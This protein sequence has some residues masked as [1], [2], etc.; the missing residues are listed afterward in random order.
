MERKKP[1]NAAAAKLSRLAHE[2]MTPAQ[3]KARSQ[4]ANEAKR[5]KA[6]GQEPPEPQAWYGL[7]SLEDEAQMI[8]WSRDKRE[9]HE[10][11]K[12][13]PSLCIVEKLN[14]KPADLEVVPR[15]ASDASAEASAL[16]SLA[17]LQNWRGKRR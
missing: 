9:L 11:A 2:S 5:R 1:K 8:A 7:Y 16:E 15:F 4:K 10:R 12:R 6:R 17:G 13:E 14:Y 3:R